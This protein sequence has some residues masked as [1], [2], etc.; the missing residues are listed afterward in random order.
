MT[1]RATPRPRQHAPEIRNDLPKGLPAANLQNARMALYRRVIAAGLRPR[2]ALVMFNIVTLPG[3]YSH[4]SAPPD[5]A[6]PWGGVTLDI[7]TL[8]GWCGMSVR[9]AQRAIRELE[10]AGWLTVEAG[11]GN[12]PSTYEPRGPALTGDK[13]S[14]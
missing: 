5:G 7:G 3:G 1:Q 4:E 12:G 8:A 6:H 10:R 13:V 14:G 2:A 9:T 11:A